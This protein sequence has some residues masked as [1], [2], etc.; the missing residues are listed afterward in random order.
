MQL[1]LP[2]HSPS[3]LPPCYLRWLYPRSHPSHLIPRSHPSHTTDFWNELYA[4]S[5]YLSSFHRHMI[6]TKLVLHW[7]HFLERT[8]CHLIPRLPFDKSLSFLS[9]DTEYL[10]LHMF[11]IIQIHI[12]YSYHFIPIWYLFSKEIWQTRAL[13]SLGR[14][15]RFS[16]VE[17]G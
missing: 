15:G 8:K 16:F 9:A 14:A 12:Q 1:L 6:N 13:Q 7:A 10:D 3:T 5:C 11:V 2:S 17:I 4:A